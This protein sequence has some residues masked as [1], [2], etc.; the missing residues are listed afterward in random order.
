M[1]LRWIDRMRA[2]PSQAVTVR[3]RVNTLFP[4]AMVAL[5][6]ITATVLFVCV[7]GSIVSRMVE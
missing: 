6:A 1:F 7:F 4:V 2:Q 5:A 3:D